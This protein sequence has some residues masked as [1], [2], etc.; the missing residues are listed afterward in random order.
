MAQTGNEI[1][2]QILGVCV[3]INKKLEKGTGS[4]PGT[5]T[6]SEKFMNKGSKDKAEEGKEGAKSVKEMIKALTTFSKVKFKTKHI[7]RTTKSLKGLF[8]TLIYI[9]RKRKT[10]LRVIKMFDVLASALGSMAKLAKAMSGLLLTVGVSILSITGSIWLSAK[11]L[12]TTPG[13]VGLLIV[14]VL[15]GIGGAMVLLGKFGG[16]LKKGAETADEMGDAMKSIGLGVVAMVG[17]LILVSYMMKIA[18]GPK[19]MLIGIGAVIGVISGMGLVFAGLGAFDEPIKKGTAVASAMALGMGALALGVLAF[20][21][22]ARL[23]TML[24]DNG[25]AT[26]R[27]GEKRGQFGQMMANIGPGLGVMGIVLVSTGLLFAGLGALSFVIIPGVLTGMLMSGAM[28]LFALATK[29]VLKVSKEVGDPEEAKSTISSMVSG[30]LTGLITGVS[31]ALSGGESGLKGFANGIKNTAIL[32]HGIGILMGVSVAL[33]MFA[34]AMTAFATLDNMRV[35]KSYDEKTGEPKFGETVNVKDVGS[36]ITSTIGEFLSGLLENTQDLTK[37]KARAIKKM[38]RAL[39]GRRG[40]LTAVIQFADVLKTFSQFGPEGKIGYAEMIDSGQ[41]DEDGNIIWEQKSDF[42][43]ITEVTT[44]ITESFGKFTRELAAGVEGV[45]GREKTRIMRMAELLI[46]KKRGTVTGWFAADKPGL[47]EPI[48]AFSDTLMIYSKFGKEGRVPVLDKDGN[49]TNESQ[50]MK[51]IVSKIVSAITT[52]SSELN[53]QLSTDI[54]GDEAGKKLDKFKT[55]FEGLSNLSTASKGLDTTAI[56]ILSLSDSIS[57]LVENINKIDLEKLNTFME[58]N[59]D[60]KGFG[61]FLER[62]QTNRQKKLENKSKKIDQEYTSEKE[63]S[64]PS[65]DTF[66]KTEIDLSDLPDKVASAVSGSL[67]NG[68]FSFIFNTDKS[69]VL[70]FE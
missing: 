10:I 14:G 16:Q 27:K 54:D 37:R 43:S 60:N 52:F 45:S 62:M 42:V 2:K 18:P 5:G 20:V 30:V 19:S 3:Q 15:A 23:I 7:N 28:V 36:T 55:M 13:K 61:G 17:S 32:M 35:I 63:I 66:N 24:G 68:Q 59:K 50:P 26:N 31:T 33:S 56:S 67:R 39:T 70:S 65:G 8:D 41:R 48:N 34:K 40:I 1:L 44:N 29:K 25:D 4:D 53:R 6:L 58:I 22:V 51:D 9:G 49:P 64:K 69:G 38:G 47:L 12:K 46:G 57:S 11:M 21:G